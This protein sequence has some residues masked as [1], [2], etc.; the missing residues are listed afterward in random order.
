MPSEPE[1]STENQNQ[2]A[3]A[4]ENARA[5]LPN[6][7]PLA[8]RNWR[9][10]EID[11][12]ATRVADK[13]VTVDEQAATPASAIPDHADDVIIATLG[14]RQLTVNAGATAIFQL[15]L[16]NNG[17]C[18]ALFK[19]H[20]EGWIFEHWLNP[21]AVETESIDNEAP[22][23]PK[24][25]H[26]LLHPGERTSLQI[27]I[28]P[29]RAPSTRAGDHPVAIVVRAAEYPNHFNRLVATLTIAPYTDFVLGQLRPQPATVSW[30]KRVHLLSLPITNRGNEATTFRLQALDARRR[31]RV[32]FGSARDSNKTLKQ[33][34]SVTLAPG[35]KI[36]LP[37][38][39][40][41]QA[42]PLFG[43]QRQSTAL[44]IVVA[45]GD[46]ALSPRI[47]C[48][49]FTRTP[50]LG[51]WQL[52]T[53]CSFLVIALLG[54]SLLGLTGLVV[55]RSTR[56]QAHANEALPSQAPAVL[57]MIALVVNVPAARPAGMNA[58]DLPT[59]KTLQSGN[60]AVAP[61]STVSTQAS[62]A[63]R[64]SAAQVTGPGTP[65]PP[66][67]RK[68][69]VVRSI[70]P[71][72][73]TKRQT[74]Q[75]QSTPRKM[76]YQQM[77]QEIG[78]RYDLNWRMLAAQAYIESSFDAN[79]LGQKGALGLMQIMPDTWREWSGV[80][81]SPDPFDTYSNV[82]V[83]AVYLDYLRT[84]LGKRDH[85]QV[86]WMLVAYNWGIDK[87]LHHLDNGL[88]WDDLPKESR[89]Y[90]QNIMRVAETI[91]VR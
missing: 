32:A 73:P 22:S 62:S 42:L 66:E 52:L 12:E 77:F 91:P 7:L 70:T 74:A 25:L 14:V 15:S 4:A 59:E 17:D 19:V 43:L 88:G 26:A 3:E 51:P 23:I 84:T 87:V 30:F 47:V 50:L 33:L 1:F 85:A 79:A 11:G 48:A 39:V 13:H 68:A 41:A 55:W 38:R 34:S 6:E 86:K 20:V 21:P 69:P 56:T 89:Q 71:A 81:K 82:L 8:L 61:S 72:Q 58:G 90:A 28:S 53:L 60:G 57:P 45:P 67:K 9:V 54:I 31:W 40:R 44:R 65:A 16:L 36:H 2:A 24:P 37:I 35:Q 64:V 46:E 10:I 83:A 29:P 49:E 75:V 18:T 78:R 76:T 80:V 5:I 63:P 27:Q